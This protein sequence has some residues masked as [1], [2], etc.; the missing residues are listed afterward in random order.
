MQQKGVLRST[1]SKGTVCLLSGLHSV[2]THTPITKHS[3]LQSLM[4]ERTDRSIM[5][6]WQPPANPQWAESDVYSRTNLP[7]T[8]AHSSCL[9]ITQSQLIPVTRDN[10]WFARFHPNRGVFNEV[11][12]ERCCSALG[13][14]FSIACLIWEQESGVS[15]SYVATWNIIFLRVSLL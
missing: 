14:S 10:L 4:S 2:H 9:V 1:P 13:P 6:T 12:S 15:R 5:K 3:G 11:N 7:S 8:S